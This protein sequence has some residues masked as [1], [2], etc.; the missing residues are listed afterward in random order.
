MPL[1]SAESLQLE[2]H[3]RSWNSNKL[4]AMHRLYPGGVTMNMQSYDE[5]N[6][7]EITIIY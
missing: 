1:V 4:K 3:E 5:N 2:Q 7:I 6:M